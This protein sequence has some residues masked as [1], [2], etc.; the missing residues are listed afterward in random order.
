MASGNSSHSS[1]D[2][3]HNFDCCTN[4][5]PCVSV[6]CDNSKNADSANQFIKPMDFFNENY[7]PINSDSRRFQTR[8]RHQ[9]EKQVSRQE[10]ENGAHQTVST[11]HEQYADL[12]KKYDSNRVELDKKLTETDLCKKMCA[13]LSHDRESMALE[14]EE[15]KQR[16]AKALQQLE[17]SMHEKSLLLCD[18]D[19]VAQQREM[20][21]QEI[22][23]LLNER[24]ME[25]QRV[26]AQRNTAKKDLQT[27]LS[28]RN[29]VLEENQKLSDDLGAAKA[30]LEKIYKN[31]QSLIYEN[32][33]LKRNRD[34]LISE[35]KCLR[36]RL[37]EKELLSCDSGRADTKEMYE[38][39]LQK[40][41]NEVE[42]AKSWR[43]LA[44]TEREKIVQ[45]RDSVKV[46]NDELQKQRDKAVSDLLQA[47]RSNEEITKQKDEAVS[48]IEH[49][50]KQL[51]SQ[52]RRSIRWNHMPYDVDALPKFTT[53]MIEIDMS[54][55][56]PSDDIGIELESGREDSQSRHDSGLAVTNVSPKSPAYGK[57]RPSDT[58]LF[59]NK[60]DC[61]SFSKRMAIDSIRNAGKSCCLI[62]KRPQTTRAHMYAA[63]LNM[64]KSR[65]HGLSLEPGIFVAKVFP[66][67]LASV[68]SDLSVGDRILSINHMSME[69]VTCG[70]EATSYLE[71]MHTETVNI[72]GLKHVTQPTVADTFT[73][74]SPNR[75]VT[76]FTQTDERANCDSEMSR[77]NPSGNAKSTS[78]ISEM[79]NKFRGKIHMNGHT[80][81]GSTTSDGDSLYQENDAIAALDSVLNIEN[82]S[83]SSVKIKENLFKRSKK[84]KKES[85]KEINKNLGTWPRA[86][87]FNASVAGQDNHTGTIVQHRKKER[88]ALS[89]FTGPISL[90]KDD[91]LSASKRDSYFGAHNYSA[92]PPMSSSKP[93]SSLA[94]S[95]R[96]SNPN[97]LQVLYQPS[98]LNRH[99]VYS[100]LETEPALLDADT[101]SKDLT[102]L[103]RKHHHHYY[104][105]YH[106]QNNNRLSLNITPSSDSNA[107]YNTL[108]NR[109]NVPSMI[110]TT[111]PAPS[112][113]MDYTVLKSSNDSLL[114]SKVSSLD[115]K[116]SPHHQQHQQQDLISLKSQNS[117]DSFLSPK[118]APLSLEPSKQ[119]FASET[120]DFYHKRLSKNVSK[121][122]SDSDSLGMESISSPTSS[123][124]STLPS[125]VTNNRAQTMLA[126]SGRMHKIA[127]PLMNPHMHPH[128][129]R[130][131]Q[132]SPLTIP[133][134]QSI[135]LSAGNNSSDK[136]DFEFGQSL[137]SHAT[138]MDLDPYHRKVHPMRDREMGGYGGYGQMFEGGTFP[139]KKDN[140]R[141]RIPSNPSVASRSSDMKDSSGSIE[142]SEPGQPI[143]MA[144]P[145]FKVEV[146]GADNP[147]SDHN[148]IRRITINKSAARNLGITIRCNDGGGI[149]VSS[150][151]EKRYF[152]SADLIGYFNFRRK[153]FESRLIFS[154][155]FN[156]IAS[157]AGLRSGD[158]L[159]EVCGINMR[160]ANHKIA[161]KI[162]QQ[163]GN[164]MTMLA[165][166]CPDSK[167]AN[168][169][170]FRSRSLD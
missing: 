110:E 7:E 76:T 91:K 142:H 135:D 144:L 21:L 106:H 133:A 57:L 108:M 121:Y 116:H 81:K 63:Q 27:T 53:E 114:N 13:D 75:G 86:N 97:P 28:E 94:G 8:I 70:K 98:T 92:P 124:T 165:Q 136:I 24:T 72:I 33:A 5:R 127:T 104:N 87:I 10:K 42:V 48:E 95:S 23:Q 79:F 117:I 103:N 39:E 137:H 22:T 145:P 43:D 16:L 102:Y 77:N 58:I 45:E 153:R 164:P 15:L 149:F 47:I 132:T 126:T 66:N 65:N 55:T 31:D 168:F 115:F 155:I 152:F 26:T 18:R 34:E 67:T 148:P 1:H 64:Q 101:K 166:Y 37:K 14:K 83:S 35:V 44:I 60:I 154:R 41:K 73:R 99:S 159:L 82:S 50:R 36:E 69:G 147:L 129:N 156:S 68:E 100:A 170:N 88:P 138:T 146:L 85:T 38:M 59:I 161:A 131:R 25:M 107:L 51:E 29:G 90:A 62:V 128:S 111:K 54:A 84:A 134:T 112:M 12:K 40:A 30:E 93:S 71:D 118:N 2:G 80:Q 49:L 151:Q 141:V 52:A 11:Y 157:R 125:Y 46:R 19:K 143:Q 96:G 20:E 169:A 160:D 123:Y 6:S 56:G 105:N 158:Q 120:S 122:P 32:E 130:L 4:D 150:V 119:L 61:G 162:L 89:L 163:C 78:K 109:K 167:N 139:R 3:E 74:T 113:S 9:L 140:Q 17:A